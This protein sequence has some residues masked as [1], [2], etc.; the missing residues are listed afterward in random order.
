L[1]RISESSSGSPGRFGQHP[2]PSLSRD[3]P[4]RG[5]RVHERRYADPED[6]RFAHRSATIE[7]CAELFD[8]NRN[9]S[10]LL[11][12][13]HAREDAANGTRLLEWIDER[14]REGVRSA[15]SAAELVEGLSTR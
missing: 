13:E 4:R 6:R 15:E 9:R 3:R 10:A 12:M 7:K 14:R 5:A 8:V 2:Y 11:G 1:E